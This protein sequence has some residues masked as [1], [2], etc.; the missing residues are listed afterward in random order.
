MNFELS[1]PSSM[2]FLVKSHRM[3]GKS[4]IRQ[5]QSVSAF[6]E[7]IDQ[8]YSDQYTSSVCSPYTQH[9]LM[10]KIIEPDS[11]TNSEILV[12]KAMNIQEQTNPKCECF[13]WQQSAVRLLDIY[14][15]VPHAIQYMHVC[16]IPLAKKEP[17][18]KTN[19]EV[20]Q[21]R[22]VGKAMFKTDK[23]KCERLLAVG[24]GVYMYIPRFLTIDPCLIMIIDFSTST[25]VCVLIH[26]WK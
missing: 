11:K 7:I 22:M 12:Q 5:I 2:R 21:Q 15:L 6:L 18:S 10:H 8:E 3:V 24:T 23:S 1:P 19:S 4:H 9:H 16:S 25:S 14:Q 20:S 17:D 26:A 13:A